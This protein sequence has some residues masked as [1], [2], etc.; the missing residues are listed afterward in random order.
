MEVP[1]SVQTGDLRREG[2]GSWWNIPTQE[3]K[4][5]IK[6]LR[7]TACGVTISL[8][9]YSQIPG[10]YVICYFS[11][12]CGE[13]ADRKQLRRGGFISVYRLKEYGT[14]WQE[15]PGGRLRARLDKP[16][17]EVNTALLRLCPSW[18][19]SCSLDSGP[20]GWCHSCLGGTFLFS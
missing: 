1:S 12:C 4:K 7:A 16:Q 9:L 6:W 15:R 19:L 20:R 14:S 11:H 5:K 13:M 8:V 10:V 2:G 17:A 3:I 18:H